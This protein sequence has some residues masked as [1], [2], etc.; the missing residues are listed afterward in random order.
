MDYPIE[1]TYR[2]IDGKLERYVYYP[3]SCSITGTSTST[4]LP[5]DTTIQHFDSFATTTTLDADWYDILKNFELKENKDVN[6]KV[7]H[8]NEEYIAYCE[9]FEDLSTERVLKTL[10]AVKGRLMM[11]V[12]PIHIQ[13]LECSMTPSVK[14]NIVTASK[15]LRMYG[16]KRPI[17]ACFDEYGRPLPDTI[18][19]DTHE[20]ITLKLVN[21]KD[22]G[23]YYLELKA[24]E[25]PVTT[26]T[27]S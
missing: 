19:L 3:K 15:R 5:Y 9:G 24:I 13:K 16:K 27:P 10:S 2:T 18:D 21:E 8:K 20:G 7:K 11:E 4:T 23:S 12:A 25:F 1:T 22:Y 17:V 26:Y 6:I 14:N